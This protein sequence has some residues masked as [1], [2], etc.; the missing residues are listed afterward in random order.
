MFYIYFQYP[1]LNEVWETYKKFDED[2]ESGLTSININGVCDNILQKKNYASND[3]NK[4]F[5]R[6]LVRNLGCYNY[7]YEYY[8]QHKDRCTILYY[9]VYKTAKEKN[10]D[11]NLINDIFNNSYSKTCTYNRIAKCYYYAYYDQFEEPVNMIFLD[12]FQKYMNIVRDNLYKP[13]DKNNANL[14]NYI[15]KCAYIYK[16]TNEQYCVNNHADENKRINT[17]SML[18][19]FQQ[20]FDTFLT[21]ERYK[22][23]FIPFLDDIGN[24]NNSDKCIYPESELKSFIA[25]VTNEIKSLNSR[26]HVIIFL[27][28]DYNIHRRILMKLQKEL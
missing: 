17:C 22:S 4:E 7:D 9:W 10:I 27:K 21:G 11:I 8:H 20:T 16:K 25:R 13:N 18:S 23:Y 5:C 26:S 15:C 12:I 6:K 19:T 3:N 14:I 2:V 24:I 28:I 1:F